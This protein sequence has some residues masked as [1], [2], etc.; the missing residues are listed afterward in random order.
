MRRSYPLSTLVDLIIEYDLY[1][2]NDLVILL[3]SDE[4]Y[5]SLLQHLDM[6]YSFIRSYLFSRSSKKEALNG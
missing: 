5:S 1:S 2:I 6:N 3:V 4:E